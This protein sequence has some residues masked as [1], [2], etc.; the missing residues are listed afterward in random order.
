[1]FFIKLSCTGTGNVRCRLD[2]FRDRN[3]IERQEE[4]KEEE[5]KGRKGEEEERG[6]D[7]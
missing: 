6:E 4:G 3:C 1:M 2:Y 5:G 7:L